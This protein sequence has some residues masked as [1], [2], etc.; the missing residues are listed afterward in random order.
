MTDIA[1]TSIVFCNLNSLMKGMDYILSD[2]NVQVVVVKNRFI[3]DVDGY[4]DMLMNV[5]L[6]DHVCEIQFHL[7]GM[8]M[9][10]S[11]KFIIF[12]FLFLPCMLR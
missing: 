12:I 2:K 5:V 10:M 7:Q 11:A 9:I 4:S 6:D 8:L 3:A 1:R